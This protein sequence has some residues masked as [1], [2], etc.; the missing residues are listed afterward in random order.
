MQKILSN[1]STTQNAKGKKI[2]LTEALTSKNQKLMN[3]EE[4]QIGSLYLPKVSQKKLR[5]NYSLMEGESNISKVINRS[6][7][8]KMEK[9]RY[10]EPNVDLFL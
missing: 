7:M 4:N 3:V 8:W 1:V 5:G 10:F 9:N 6:K 2:F